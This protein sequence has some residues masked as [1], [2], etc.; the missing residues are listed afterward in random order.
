MDGGEAAESMQEWV[1]L[2]LVHSIDEV[3]ECQAAAGSRMVKYGERGDIKHTCS[4]SIRN[5]VIE[6]KAE[7]VGNCVRK[8]ETSQ[9]NAQQV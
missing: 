8:S 4:Q 5:N 3:V 7:K 6:M 1:S 2:M 9:L